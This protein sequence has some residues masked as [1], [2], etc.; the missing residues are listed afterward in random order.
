MLNKLSNISKLL[1]ILALIFSAGCNVRIPAKEVHRVVSPDKLVDAVVVARE[2]DATVLTPTELYIVATGRDWS[3]E[4]PVLKGDNFSEMNISWQEPKYL[5][6]SYKKAR[7]FNFT[8]FWN[9]SAVQDY[10]YVVELRL[11]PTEKKSLN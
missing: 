6:I 3:K 1:F 8:N 11:S 4:T 7:V 2:T 9:S 5:E 10:R